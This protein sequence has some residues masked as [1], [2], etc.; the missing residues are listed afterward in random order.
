[1][2]KMVDNEERKRKIADLALE[3][4]ARRG[5]YAA[6]FGEIAD[7]CGLSRT[8][9]YN[10]FKNKDEI[11]HYAVSE[12]LDTITKKIEHIIQQ[13]E[14]SLAQ[15]LQ[16]IYQVFTNDIG[17]GKYTSIILDL[18]L[19]LKR[20]NTHLAE[21]L[22]EATKALRNKIEMLFVS[23]SS[24]LSSSQTAFATTLFFSLIESSIIH[25]FFTDGAFIQ[26]NIGSILH[27]L[28]T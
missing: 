17:E 10:Y 13:Q 2:P 6:S 16:K 28:G 24:L 8:N 18:A 20:E 22:D 27:M 25:S 12:L 7:T 15:K 5:Y 1:M 26:N 14:L 9:V 21:A 19:R 3:L 11:F 4:F 23:E